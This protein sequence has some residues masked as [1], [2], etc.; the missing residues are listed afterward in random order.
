LSHRTKDPILFNSCGVIVCRAGWP[1]GMI[2]YQKSKSGYILEDLEPENVDIFLG[3]LVQFG[4][5]GILYFCGIF[6]IYFLPFWHLVKRKIWQ[7]ACTAGLPDGIFS[8]QKSR[9][10]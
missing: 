6:G 10:G 7:P 5:V 2:A 8:N 3:K 1:D 9:F 4:L